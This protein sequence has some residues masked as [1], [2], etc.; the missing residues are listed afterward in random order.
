[1]TPHLNEDQLLDLLLELLPPER[2]RPLLEHVI[3]C[4]T[5]EELMRSRGAQLERIAS[6]H[7]ARV[8]ALPKPTPTA[9][10]MRTKLASP[11]RRSGLFARLLGSHRSRWQLLPLGGLAIGLAIAFLLVMPR[12][13]SA[14]MTL[15]P[16]WLP[17]GASIVQ[18]QEDP[19]EVG[20][21]MLAEG[22][23]AYERRDLPRAIERL[24]HASVGHQLESFRRLYLSSALALAGEYD[25][26]V[27]VLR[28]VTV[29]YLPEPWATEG[30]WT[31]LVALERGGHHASADSLRRVL[32]DQPGEIGERVK[33]AS[34]PTR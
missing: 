15:E 33:R 32:I 30:Y 27:S 1:M 18:R 9:D 24:E 28:P 34:M 14:P 25:R 11:A 3:G 19:H 12:E 31:L 13:R 16:S 2:E 7:S 26:A 4:P 10:D 20:R 5:C 22:L 8:R 17:S 29:A 21:A 23:G 6:D